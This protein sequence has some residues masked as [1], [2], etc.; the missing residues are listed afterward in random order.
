MWNSRFWKTCILTFISSGTGKDRKYF[1][2]PNLLG[3]KLRFWI[4]S[5]ELWVFFSTFVCDLR[6]WSWSP[7]FD[8][9]L[10]KNQ[11]FELQSFLSVFFLFSLVFYAFCIPKWSKVSDKRTINTCIIWKPFTTKK[12]NFLHEP[13][14]IPGISNIW[15]IIYSD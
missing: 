7:Q 13:Q 15:L 6:D 3:E 9:H 10:L 2:F 11:C 1:F 8:R 14:P 12:V 5:R 4:T